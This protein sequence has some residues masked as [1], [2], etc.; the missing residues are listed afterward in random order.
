MRTA[1]IV[2]RRRVEGDHPGEITTNCTL[3]ARF[4][5]PDADVFERSE[6][7]R[8]AKSK[9]AVQESIQAAATGWRRVSDQTVAGRDERNLRGTRRCLFAGKG[10]APK[11]PLGPFLGPDL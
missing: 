4:A 11:R 7:F 8:L 10:E 9:K 5:A 3:R 1:R 2:A 6:C